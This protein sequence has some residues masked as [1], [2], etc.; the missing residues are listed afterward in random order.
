M[1]I[2]SDFSEVHHI[3]TAETNSMI[4]LKVWN[5]NKKLYVFG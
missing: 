5:N 2:Q 3:Y 4:Y 1:G